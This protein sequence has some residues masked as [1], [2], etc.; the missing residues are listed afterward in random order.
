MQAI[1]DGI[2][3]AGILRVLEEQAR[4]PKLRSDQWVERQNMK[5][6]HAL[7]YLEKNAHVLSN[8]ILKIG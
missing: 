1:G 4:H 8:T 2:M 3:E 5:L 7:D 6:I